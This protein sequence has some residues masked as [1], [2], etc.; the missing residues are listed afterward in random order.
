MFFGKTVVKAEVNT[1]VWSQR[2]SQSRSQSGSQNRSQHWSQTTSCNKFYIVSMP[3][4]QPPTSPPKTKIRT[5][6]SPAS[7]TIT[8]LQIM[9]VATIFFRFCSLISMPQSR[10]WLYQ[11]KSVFKMLFR[12]CIMG[13]WSKNWNFDRPE[14]KND[15]M[16]F[17]KNNKFNNKTHIEICIFSVWSLDGYRKL[18]MLTQAICWKGLSTSR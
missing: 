12:D 10:L 16:V 6:W 15:F 4:T 7:S 3:S 5:T 1:G 17:K 9:V 14:I 13:T 2:G 8:I 18:S 11:L